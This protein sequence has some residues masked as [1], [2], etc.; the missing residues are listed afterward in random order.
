[1]HY[2]IRNTALQT[3]WPWDPQ[4]P[5]GHYEMSREKV[6]TRSL[7]HQVGVDGDP[8]DAEGKVGR[9]HL[10]PVHIIERTGRI[11]EYH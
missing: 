2:W 7:P 3:L 10:G 5:V 11:P 4:G 1:M 8:D 9:G 6:R